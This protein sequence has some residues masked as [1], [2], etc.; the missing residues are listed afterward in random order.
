M[1]GK[2]IVNGAW[3]TLCNTGFLRDTPYSEVN[4]YTSTER[5]VQNVVSWFLGEGKKGS[6][7]VATNHIG[8][9]DRFELYMK[10]K[11]HTYTK[12]YT[13]PFTLDFV[14]KYDC[15]FVGGMI[16]DNKV[17]IDYVRNGGNVY[18]CGGVWD[19]HK[20]SA[21]GWKTFLNTFGL[22][23][24]NSGFHKGNYCDI[25]GTHPIFEGVKKL[26][27]NR[28]QFVIDIDEESEANEVIQSYPEGGLVAIYDG[29][30]DAPMVT[31]NSILYVGNANRHADEFIEIVNSGSVHTDISGWKI[32]A[33]NRNNKD[34]VFPEGAII[35]AGQSI[36]VYTNQV[37]EE[38][39][40]FSF[41][42]KKQVWGM[43][44]HGGTGYL[45]D[46]S[47]AEVSALGYGDFAADNIDTGEMVTR[48]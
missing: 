14:K 41:G 4:I 19:K 38:S 11:G 45:Y 39:G 5:F 24:D 2:I 13:S 31:I 12:D 10:E 36:R 47:G 20:E 23:F 3:R 25:T 37:H 8:Y 46:A 6:F 43:D 33:G 32:H 15:V 9:Q 26:F 28:Y 1:T 18:L 44:P 48:N 17:L 7:L 21:I 29:S 42:W 34:F 40:G 22:K 30:R 27:I 35:Q 16:V